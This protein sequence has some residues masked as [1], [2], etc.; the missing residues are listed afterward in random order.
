M[1]ATAGAEARAWVL[2]ITGTNDLFGVVVGPRN[3]LTFQVLVNPSQITPPDDTLIE[4][5]K[6][7][8]FPAPDS[9]VRV[10]DMSGNQWIAIS[11]SIIQWWNPNPPTTENKSDIF[12]ILWGNV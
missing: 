3:L 2:R 6:W 5:D 4:W 8:L 11:N 9:R 7:R 12:D 10:A 1:T